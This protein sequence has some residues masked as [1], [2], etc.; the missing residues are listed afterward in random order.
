M[1]SKE[2]EEYKRLE[3]FAKYLQNMPKDDLYFRMLERFPLAGA[4][5][6]VNYISSYH[7]GFNEGYKRGIR[8]QSLKQFLKWKLKELFKSS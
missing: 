5:E 4:N 7:L 1:E 2:I 8:E 6:L 3:G